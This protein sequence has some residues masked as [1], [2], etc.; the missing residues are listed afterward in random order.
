M[1]CTTGPDER[2]SWDVKVGAQSLRRS[3]RQEG[4]NVLGAV[5]T[6][7]NSFE[8][9]LG[10]RISRAWRAFWKCA[11]VLCCRSAPI[12][13]RLSLLQLLVASSLFWCSGS[14]NL[15]A[16]QVSKLKGLQ[17]KML[18]KMITVRRITHEDTAAHV[19]RLHSRIKH[20]KERHAFEDWDR[21]YHRSIFKWAGHVVRFKSWD[22]KRLTYRVLKYFDWRHIQKIADNNSGN[23]LHG[24]KIRTWRWERPLYRYFS[25]SSW[26][27]CAQ[28]KQSWTSQ[29]EDMVNWRCSTR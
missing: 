27:E 26:Q 20:F 7:D 5:V 29:L 22:R 4:F 16:R 23:Q 17:Q 15:T 2:Y 24:R 6:F 11:D 13:Q 18:R 21:I 10:N 1:W 25:E 3:P 12:Q 8:K 9:E 14:W 19:A 28:C